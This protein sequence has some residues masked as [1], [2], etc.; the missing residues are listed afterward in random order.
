MTGGPCPGLSTSPPHFASTSD[1][2]HGTAAAF[3]SRRSDGRLP[4]GGAQS[5]RCDP[6]QMTRACGPP[7][8]LAVAARAGGR[9]Q[10]IMP[11]GVGGYRTFCS[12]VSVVDRQL[13]M[14]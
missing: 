7:E 14:R 10:D 3:R 1:G 5:T 2:H 11:G 9:D 6:D 12:V 4:P 13:L 8:D